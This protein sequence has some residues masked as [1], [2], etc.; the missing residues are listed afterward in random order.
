MDPL[1]HA[2]IPA[3]AY[4]AVSKDPCLLALAVLVAGAVI[5]DLDALTREHRSYL[6][7][8]PFAVPVILP[9]LLTG[10]TYVWLFAIGV[11]FHILLDFFTGVIPFLYP[12]RKT[13]YGLS[14]RMRA[15]PGGFGLS[16]RVIRAD[17]SPRRDYD[18]DLGGGLVML[19]VA[20]AVAALRLL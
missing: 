11:W 9:A 10:N 20:T 14:V 4:L 15:G 18:V 16:V 8:L 13:G 19:I 5:P 3:L 2:S 12:F 17:P 7:G 6:H 1:K